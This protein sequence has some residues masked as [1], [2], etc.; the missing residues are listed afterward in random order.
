MDKFSKDSYIFKSELSF[1]RAKEQISDRTLRRTF[2][3]ME[4]TQKDF[5]GKINENR[6][7]LIS[8]SWLPFGAVC[9]VNGEIDER[10]STLVCLTTKLHLAF[11]I[12]FSVWAIFM[13]G[14]VFLF[15]FTSEQQVHFGP[16]LV[17]PFAIAFFRLFL[18]GMYVLARNN[19][20]SRLKRALL[21]SES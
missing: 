5:I 20:L 14:A 11:R 17:L 1:D 6:F 3:G 19:A 12:L 21:L 16:I 15:L 10:D 8:S 18:H 9:V 4:M 13:I 2:L 7:K